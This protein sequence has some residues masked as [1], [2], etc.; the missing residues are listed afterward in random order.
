MDFWC[1]H[2]ERVVWDTYGDRVSVYEKAK[3]LLKFGASDDIDTSLELVWNQGGNET[4]VS[5]NIITHF[6]SSSGSDTGSMKVEG[7]TVDGSGN[8]T[9][10]V[11]DV[12]LAGQTKTALTTPLARTSRAYNNTGTDWV[13]DIYVAEDVT[14]TA[15]VPQTASAIHV[16][17]NAGENQTAKA[18]TTFSQNDYFFLTNFYASVGQ[19]TAATVDFYLQVA[20]KDK[21]FRNQF[22]Y[23][24]A[25]TGGIINYDFR[26]FVII[27]PNSDVRI[28]ALSSANDTSCD[29]GFNGLLAIKV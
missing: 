9:F 16:K 23:D 1:A 6:A 8:F 4:L 15:G 20:L 22:I 5:S 11:Q 29:A 26:P 24:A 14:F 7:H 19:K 13:G 10:V 28:M 21:V 25:S 27:P 12:T 2:A 3:D 18:A 17:V